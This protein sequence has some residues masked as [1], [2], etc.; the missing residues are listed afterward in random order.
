[1]L[2]AA[3][4][5]RLIRLLN[6]LRDLDWL[7][8]LL[9]RIC[10]G[11][12]FFE[13]GRGKLFYRLDG[14]IE[15]FE[16]WGIPLADVQA[17]L[18]ASIE[19]VGGLCLIL[20]LGTRLFAA[21]LS[22]VMAVAILT[23]MTQEGVTQLAHDTLGDFLYLPEVAFLLIFVWLVFTG[24]GRVSLDHVLARKLGLVSGSSAGS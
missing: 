11:L 8:I 1:M 10:I 9:V 17:P 24:P 3:M 4:R 6:R 22:G 18:V 13:S 16:R 20:G 7:P 12:E 19:L 5:L 2:R 15:D 21:M 23:L 14:L